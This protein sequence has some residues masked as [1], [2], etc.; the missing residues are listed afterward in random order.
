M[1]EV[2]YQP[3]LPILVEFTK[4]FHLSPVHKNGINSIINYA[5][6]IQT[7]TVANLGYVMVKDAFFC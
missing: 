1:T 5:M 4:N 3:I 7:V 2:T 6:M